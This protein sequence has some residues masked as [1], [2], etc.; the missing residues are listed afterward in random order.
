MWLGVFLAIVAVNLVVDHAYKTQPNALTL[1]LRVVSQVAA[2]TVV[3]YLTGW[4]P[5][6]WGAYAFIV[7][8]NVARSG[9]RVCV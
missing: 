1:N 9:S 3:I 4:G 6:L 5:V 7:L 2:V 8:E